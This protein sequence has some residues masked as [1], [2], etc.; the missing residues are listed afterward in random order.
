MMPERIAFTRVYATAPIGRSVFHMLQNTFPEFDVD[1]FDITRMLKKYPLTIAYNG[2][3]TAGLY[4]QDILQRYKRPR[5]SF[6]ATPYLHRKVNDLVRQAIYQH[7][8][9]YRF[10]FQLQSLFDVSLPDLPHFIY[11]DHT[12]LANLAYDGFHPRSLYSPE[13]IALEKESYARA[14]HIFTR[15]HNISRSLIEQYDVPAEK[16]TCA[17]VGVNTPQVNYSPPSDR[18]NSKHILFVGLDWE[19]KGGPELLAAFQQLLQRHPDARLTIVG[20]EP[21]IDLPQVT[22]VGRVSV[23][24]VHH[25]YQQASIFCLP[26]KLEPF[27]V[28]FIEAMTFQLPIV[29]TNIGAI[30]DF[31]VNNQNGYLVEPGEVTPLVDALDCLLSSAHRRQLFGQTGHELARQRYN[32]EAVGQV[33]RNKIEE[34]IESSSIYDRQTVR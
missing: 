14:T 27:G 1:I 8:S 19:R 13:W 28:A 17:Y 15:S 26:T 34:K 7:P 5:S 16:I 12:H 10:T 31:V 4:G 24:E 22:V 18:Y 25:F 3:L 21:E 2:L 32:W 23:A 11:T 6:L 33:I 9:R 20:A 30:P 29:A